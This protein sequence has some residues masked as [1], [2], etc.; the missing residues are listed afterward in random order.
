ML[1]I[2][3]LTPWL[4]EQLKHA[5]WFPWMRP[6][7]GKLNMLVPVLTA[8][9]VASGITWAFDQTSGELTVKGLIPS[10]IFRGLL[11]WIGGSVTQHF[12][13]ERAIKVVA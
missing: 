3:A 7:I 10:D 5:R 11:L 8:A 12:S 9:I 1:I 6:Y 2:S 4:L 13:Y